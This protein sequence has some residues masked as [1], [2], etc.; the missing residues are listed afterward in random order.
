MVLSKNA[1]DHSSVSAPKDAIL[2]RWK[3]VIRHAG[4]DT[5]VAAHSH[6]ELDNSQSQWVRTKEASGHL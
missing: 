5:G 6:S 3:L 4:I 2:I 1:Y